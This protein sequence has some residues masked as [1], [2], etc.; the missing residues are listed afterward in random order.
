MSKGISG[1]SRPRHRR[2]RGVSGLRPTIRDPFEEQQRQDA[3]SVRA[4]DGPTQIRRIPRGVTQDVE[5]SGVWGLRSSS[6]WQSKPSPC[7]ITRQRSKFGHAPESLPQSCLPRWLDAR[8]FI[9]LF[10]DPR[11]GQSSSGPPQ[12]TIK[13]PPMAADCAQ[14]QLNTD[15]Q[16]TSPTDKPRQ[17]PNV[18]LEFWSGR[19]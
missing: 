18:L 15:R 4:V 2:A 14:I 5:S 10:H 17:K 16:G 19:D 1:S 3:P 13:S 6:N 8:A 11:S 12:S 7:E 9:V